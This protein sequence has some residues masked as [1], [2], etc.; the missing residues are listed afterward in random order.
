MPIRLKDF[1]MPKRVVKDDASA[2]PTFGR[3]TA[4]PFEIGYA[5][6]IGNSLRRVLLS[7][8]EGWAISSV[9]ITGAP[10]EF[11]SLP[12][13]RED[14]TE[15]VFALKKTLVKAKTP[16]K[17]AI[18]V[19]VS[20]KGPCTV[21]AA[22]LAAE[23]PAIEVLNPAHHICTV[24]ETGKFEMEVKITRGRGFCQASWDRDPARP[25]ETPKQQE[26]G[27]IPL[28]RIYSPVARVN[29]EVSN[30]RVGQ[31]TDYERLALEITTDGRVA[32]DDALVHA[33]DIL[34]QHLDVFVNYNAALVEEEEEEEPVDTATQEEQAA[35]FKL[36]VNEIELSVRAANCLNMANI[37]TVGELCSRTE[38]D[39][40]KYRNFGKKSLTEIKEKLAQMGLR[41]GMLPRPP[42]LEAADSKPEE[43]GK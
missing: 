23:N 24:N 43:A 17:D 19:H 29:F 37:A 11:C 35:K 3:F 31:Q 18:L 7:S 10:H 14:V 4:E 6:T 26:I 33:A 1:E 36:N 5:R 32:P 2:T 25:D 8:I 34:R 20:R 41:L 9:R 42:E 22:D 38:A 21:T 13:V 12:G 15:I 28:D 40:L 16:T 27:V 39:M 30:C